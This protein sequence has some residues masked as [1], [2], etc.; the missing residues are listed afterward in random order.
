MNLVC[1]LL[2]LKMITFFLDAADKKE[3]DIERSDSS[4]RDEDMLAPAPSDHQ[5]MDE[6]E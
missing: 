4:D 6:I 3:D 1:F 2:K 5:H